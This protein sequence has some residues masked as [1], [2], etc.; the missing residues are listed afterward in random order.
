[1]NRL[2]A[3][4]EKGLI[5][6]D[7]AMG[8][9][10]QLAGLSGGAAP[11]S[12]VLKRPD[13]V[14]KIH[15][16]YIEAGS[17]MVET[18]TFGANRVKLRALGL[19]EQ[20]EEINKKAAQLAGEAAGK[21]LVAGSV[22]PTGKMM[23]PYGELSFK[24]ALRVFSEQIG[25]LTEAGVDLLCIETM[26]DIQE[27]RAA[28][29]AGREAGIP[30]IAQMTFS[31]N[32]FTLTGTTPEAAAV[33]LDGLGV[34]VIG[35]N[36][37]L[38]SRELIPVIRRMSEVTNRPL[39]VQPNAG[40]PRIE[41]EEIIY[42]EKPEDFASPVKEFISCN[43]Q[44]IGG[45]CGTTP[46]FIKAIKKQAED[47]RTEFSK[48]SSGNISYLAS[49]YRHMKLE[50]NFP[51]RIAQNVIEGKAGINSIQNNTDEKVVSD[52][53]KIILSGDKSVNRLKHLQLSIRQ[54][55]ILE[56]K[57]IESNLLEEVLQ[58][59]K[60][61]ALLKIDLLEI[62]TD[63]LVGLLK[64]AG[65]YGASVAGEIEYTTSVQN[66]NITGDN[67]IKAARL[68]SKMAEE[69]IGK[70]NVY[71]I[72]LLQ[73]GADDSRGC[74]EIV[75]FVN[76]MGEEGIKTG[77]EFIQPAESD[78]SRESKIGGL[79]KQILDR[80]EP[81]FAVIPSDSGIYQIIKEYNE[82]ERE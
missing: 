66:K 62:D 14:F 68:F 82:K 36:C 47:C 4:L 51:V 40:L 76:K 64:I 70:N 28:V 54:P 23:E 34:D 11:E 16:K 2:K 60:G 55:L 19:E 35:V 5:I 6:G 22:G 63:Q 43:V 17:T 41:G 7:G 75:D 24:E 10:L 44:I 12:W 18:N 37:S 79:R 33:I 15:R 57:E 31:E 67:Q 48:S 73:T 81:V 20:V 50:R 32:Q 27:M 78:F 59:Y 77:L 53:L 56:I 45:C 42:P 58:E 52:L 3:A 61:K 30:I 71:I 80:V 46:D 13:E 8:T 49:S 38:G 72:L 26:S 39:S 29:I 1:M 74:N 69:T 65:K 25:F 21:R 9:M